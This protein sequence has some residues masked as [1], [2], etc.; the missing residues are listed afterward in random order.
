MTSKTVPQIGV[1]SDSPYQR[2]MLQSTLSR[3]GVEV[4]VSC[5]PQQF[6]SQQET[7]VENVECWLVEMESEHADMM[8]IMQTLDEKSVPVLFGL[9]MAPHQQEVSFISWQ[10][11]LMSKLEDHLGAIA[12]IENAESLSKWVNTG[13]EHRSES[14]A[15]HGK[16]GRKASEVARDVWVLAA[17]LG[18][19]EAVKEFIDHL[20]ADLSFG[21]LYAQH[22]DAHF[23]NVLTQVLGRH[24]QL[25]LR[26]MRP[27]TALMS[28]EIQVVPVDRQI[29]FSEAGVQ[30]ENSP[31]PGP[32]GPSIDQLLAN[33][34]EYYG[35]RCHVI[36][37][38]G[39]GNDGALTIPEMQKAGCR[40]WTQSPESCAHYS[41]P[42]SVI[43][44]GC[45]AFSGTPAELAD[46]L[47]KLDRY[48]Q[49]VH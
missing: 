40:I 36:V 1:I 2:H 5:E 46:A 21:F 41:M 6:A 29:R 38:S 24:A 16:P 7:R 48:G 14:G 20:P 37:F 12:E 32:Y 13:V 28:G 44:L 15:S 17:S 45:S 22:V 31:W 26:G 27:D 42:Q 19:P 4:L 39:M 23:S 9:G 33:L 18:G 8:E 34:L 3:N 49:D 25:E 10:R 11:R 30:F 43:D 47:V 35:A